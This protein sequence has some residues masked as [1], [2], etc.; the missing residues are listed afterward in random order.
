MKSSKE[1]FERLKTDEAFAKEVGEKIQASVE[2]GETNDYKEILISI[3]GEY[4]YELE[5]DEL[6][7]LYDKATAEMSEEE[8]GKVAGGTTPVFAITFVAS[9]GC[10]AYL[11]AMVSIYQTEHKD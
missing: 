9:M 11:T 6:E 3:A 7:E 5:E 2:A 10:S 1:F 8:L 4:G